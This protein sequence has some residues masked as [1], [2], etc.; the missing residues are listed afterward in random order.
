M[1]SLFSI[2]RTDNNDHLTNNPKS[3]ELNNKLNLNVTNEDFTQLANSPGATLVD[4]VVEA[5]ASGL[6]AYAGTELGAIG[7]SLTNIAAP[8][9]VQPLVVVSSNASNT[10][11]YDDVL[12]SVQEI[13]AM[14]YVQ[15]ATILLTPDN[16]NVFRV[17]RALKPARESQTQTRN[18]KVTPL[19]LSFLKNSKVTNES[20][21]NDTNK[22]EYKAG[23]ILGA[24]YTIEITGKNDVKQK[25]NVNVTLSPT[26]IPNEVINNIMIDSSV[27]VDTL[28]RYH[29]WRGGR[30]SLFNLISG[31]DIISKQKEIS[32]KDKT[33][34]YNSIVKNKNSKISSWLFS[35]I[36]RNKNSDTYDNAV[37]A[38]AYK[39]GANT[40]I[41]VITEAEKQAYEMASKT[42]LNNYASRQ[43]LM[44][45]IHTFMLVVVDREF[46]R[47]TI[48]YKDIRDGQT[49]SAKYLKGSGS[50]SSDALTEMFKAFSQGSVPS[51]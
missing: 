21:V 20:I 22:K 28:D 37:I 1:Q 11:F 17:L 13:F 23:S 34:I 36:T 40:N 42:K 12:K 18:F 10:P 46:N 25:L 29:A 43:V 15:A 16:N 4:A 32:V 44:E 19:K 49:V 2:L 24:T 5:T 26:I 6:A 38:G 9:Q 47:V 45:S 8:L 7:G 35:F 51:F 14:Y 30:I 33:G 50:G 27:L 31:M 39:A 48:Y 3:K 41:F